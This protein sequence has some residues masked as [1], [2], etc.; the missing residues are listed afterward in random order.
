MRSGLYLGGTSL[1]F[2]SSLRIFSPMTAFTTLEQRYIGEHLL[3][4]QSRTAV[5]VQE[6]ADSLGRVTRPNGDPLPTAAADRIRTLRLAE[7][8]PLL[9]SPGQMVIRSFAA[10]DEFH[11]GYTAQLA[12]MLVPERF[13][14]PHQR[15]TEA[16]PGYPGPPFT[17]ISTWGIPFS[18]FVL[19]TE[20]DRTEVVE[21]SGRILTVRIQVPLT[22]ALRR[23][24]ACLTM[25]EGTAEELDL[26]EELANVAN[27]LEGFRDESI[28]ELD[29]GPV[30]DR[31]YPDD[32]PMDVRLGLECLAE[33]DLTG[34]AAAY[35]RLASRWIPIRQLARAS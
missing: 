33:G 20:T 12:G 30:A 15:R 35:R 29:Y 24:E 16:A 11:R 7:D 4:D 27:W 21:S 5:D 3:P 14:E 8:G 18:W 34:A 13:R 9:Y 28:L 6:L 23:A 32:S 10:V 22:I 2:V 25:L 31:V 19:V 26:H 17:R 1:P